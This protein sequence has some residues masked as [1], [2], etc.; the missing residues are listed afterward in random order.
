MGMNKKKSPTA[1]ISRTA[2]L[3]TTSQR[4]EDAKVIVGTAFGV[5]ATFITW[6]C[7]GVS[8]L[9]EHVEVSNGLAEC[10]AVVVVYVLFGMFFNLSM[11]SAVAQM[12]VPL[13]VCDV[14]HRLN[15]TSVD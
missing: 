5:F 4:Q 3:Y 12:M 8:W 6:F 7:G 14:W 15:P 9:L 2:Q 11:P 10:V 13:W 1:K